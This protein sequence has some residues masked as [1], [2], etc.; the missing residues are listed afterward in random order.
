MSSSRKK[1]LVRRFSGD[2]LPGYLPSGGFVHAG[3]V[4]LLDLGGRILPL[5]LTD[6]KH[7]SFVRDF[8]LTDTVNPEHLTRRTF[9]ARP[10]TEGLWVRLTFRTGDQLEGLAP[11]DLSVLDGLIDDGGLFL[12]PPDTRSNT[13]RLFV[14]RAHL[15]SPRA[16]R[17]Q[18]LPRRDDITLAHVDDGHAP[19]GGRARDD[20]LLRGGR[21][22]G[23]P[24]DL[25][26]PRGDEARLR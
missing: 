9:L 10:R 8:N 17:R 15:L 7:V 11:T 20:R 13:Q 2:A 14:P 21:G 19:R 1:V 22:R 24:V 23:R 6:I 25:L 4:E 26:L 5:P 3:A 16:Q 12:V 18:R